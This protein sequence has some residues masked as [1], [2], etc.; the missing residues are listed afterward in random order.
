MNQTAATLQRAFE[1]AKPFLSCD[2][3][4]TLQELCNGS[5]GP[6]FDGLVRE[7]AC[8]LVAMPKTREQDGEGVDPVVHLHYFIGGSD[9]YIVEQ[10]E[11]GG[12]DQAYGFVILNGDHQGA[13]LGYVSIAEIVKCG[14]ELDLHF[15]PRPL[16]QILAKLGRGV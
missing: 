5:E 11:I 8:R 15:A 3:F 6:Y 12:V 16:S 14:A 9:W 1:T 7:L 10:D 4:V 13:E 2:Q